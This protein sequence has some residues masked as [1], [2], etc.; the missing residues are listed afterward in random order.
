[1]SGRRDHAWVR[2]LRQLADGDAAPYAAD[3]VLLSRFASRRDEA[4]FAALVRR[5]G[6]MV[7]GVCRRL[8]RDPHDADD[9][10]QAAFLV[11]VHKASSIAPRHAVGNWLYGVA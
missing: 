6:P 4:A 8:L 11:L 1:M 2:L 10:F 9:A 3:G 7:L 5:H